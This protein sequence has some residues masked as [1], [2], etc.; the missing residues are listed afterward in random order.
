MQTSTEQSSKICKSASRTKPESE[1][2]MRIHS[3]NLPDVVEDIYRDEFIHE[4]RSFS[5]FLRDMIQKGLDDTCLETV[6]EVDLEDQ[7]EEDE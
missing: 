2:R 1:Q 6:D 4:Y 7:D 3:V 5:G